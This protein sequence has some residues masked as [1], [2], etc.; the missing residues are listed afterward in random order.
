[1]RAATRGHGIES[2]HYIEW[3]YLDSE[4]SGGY[5]ARVIAIHNGASQSAWFL[6]HGD[7]LE[8]S[9]AKEDLGLWVEVRVYDSA[10]SDGAPYGLLD[11]DTFQCPK[12]KQDYNLGTPDGSGNIKEGRWVAI[13][14]M[15]EAYGVWSGWA[16]GKS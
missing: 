10:D 5:G 15:D 12:R 8:V 11:T 3:S 9:T 7:H 1:M 13:R 2:S 6:P 16:I 4:D 14:M